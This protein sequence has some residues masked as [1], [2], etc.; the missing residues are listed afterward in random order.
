[1]DPR[2]ASTISPY[3]RSFLCSLQ[4]NG[5]KLYRRPAGRPYI[6]ALSVPPAPVPMPFFR[7]RCYGFL[8]HRSVRKKPWM[9]HQVRHDIYFVIPAEAKRISGIQPLIW[10]FILWGLK[11]TQ[12]TDKICTFS[13]KKFFYQFDNPTKALD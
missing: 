13:F 9:P 5:P 12:E 2:S 8:K 7:L 1:V 11:H 6:R 3:V 4:R 10:L